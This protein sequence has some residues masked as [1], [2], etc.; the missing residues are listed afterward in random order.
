MHDWI[1]FNH[2]I[3]KKSEATLSAVSAAA[4]YG[5]GIFT[6][7]RIQNGLPFLFDRHWK[8]LKDN[9][10]RLD[11]PLPGLHKEDLFASIIELTDRNSVVDGRCRV[12]LFD[13]SP[14]GIWTYA[15]ESN[16]R[17]LLLTSDLRIFDEGL[18]LGFSRFPVTSHSPLNT[19]K[20]CNYMERLQAYEA[21]TKAGFDEAIRLNES[22]EIVSAC[23]ANLFWIREG[24]IF[25]PSA[26]TGCLEGTT[27]SFVMEKCDVSQI[28]STVDAL[29]TADS[30]FLT[31]AGLG[32]KA[33]KEII[34]ES[35]SKKYEPADEDFY[36]KNDL[37]KLRV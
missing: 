20:S 13:E 29:R 6:T 21:A 17:V 4:L 36:L 33:V 32:V 1:S 24:R 15:G 22:G 35:E 37:S 14:S 12:T 7:L 19:I 3:I 9:A 27:R 8:R 34:F 18:T 25:T 10:E 26:K 31:S 28:E 30:V 23:M 2:Q 16:S 11:I 5:K